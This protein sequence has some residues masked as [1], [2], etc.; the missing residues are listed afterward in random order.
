MQAHGAVVT[1]GPSQPKRLSY[2]R[3]DARQGRGSVGVWG[4]TWD[5]VA[6]D[7]VSDR[8]LKA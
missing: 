1:S 7:F 4:L 5:H 2:Q 6:L 8:G 3:L